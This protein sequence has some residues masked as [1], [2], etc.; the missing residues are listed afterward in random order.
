MKEEDGADCRQWGYEDSHEE[1]RVVSQCGEGT[2]LSQETRHPCCE[3][4]DN[5][6]LQLE[7]K[8]PETM[9]PK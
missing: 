2:G 5:D 9:S 4:T 8:R 3:G 6:T 1:S 7:E